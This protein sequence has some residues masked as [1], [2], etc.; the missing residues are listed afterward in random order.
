MAGV[1]TIPGSAILQT[2]QTG[3]VLGGAAGA[4][5]AAVSQLRIPYAW[6]AESPG[7]GFDC[8]GL[9]QWAYGQ[10]GVKLP[11]TSEEQ[12]AATTPVSPANAL[13]GDLMFSEFG[14]QGQ[15][16]P[17]HVGI[18]LG[19]G[20][21]IDAPYTG[22]DVRIDNVPAGAAYGRVSGLLLNANPTSATASATASA[23]P[24]PNGCDAKG[25]GVNL[26][27]ASSIPVVG[28]L[29]P[30]VN[31]G[32]ACQIKA[33]T[34]GLLVGIG[35]V[36]LLTGAVLIASHALKGTG[37]GAA[38]GKVAGGPVGM[39]AGMVAGGV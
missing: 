29:A 16:G 13:P 32:N 12:Y 22:V 17:G 26:D 35:G 10:A 1:S 14:T 21:F 31:V 38:V 33:L 4:I 2:A 25:G 34:G 37:V 36:I 7:K 24:S 6:G 19:N 3:P 20:Q 30:A 5:A 39:I 15:S 27:L 23:A 18:Y 9:V 28:S 11:R 8:S